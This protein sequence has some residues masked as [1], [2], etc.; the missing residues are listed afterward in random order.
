[1]FGGLELAM[2]TRADRDRTLA[3]FRLLGAVCSDGTYCQE[4]AT[5]RRV[6][7][8]NFGTRYDARHAVD[9]IERLTGARPTISR[10]R[11]IYSV[12]FPAELTAAVTDVPGIGEP[13][14]RVASD[15]A[16]PD[17]VVDSGTPRAAIR[18]YLGALFGGDGCAPVILHFRTNPPTLKSVRYTQTRVDPAVLATLQTAS[19][20]PTPPPCWGSASSAQIASSRRW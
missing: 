2:R 3:F 9:D 5:G 12:R 15:R 20:S 13:G 16:L 14:K 10:S 8:V 11:T 18:E 19:T 4:S 7:R 1:M 6:V 17:L